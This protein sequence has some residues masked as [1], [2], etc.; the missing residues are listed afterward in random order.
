MH[1]NEHDRLE[2]N[3]VLR[4]MGF[5]SVSCLMDAWISTSALMER[6]RS[7]TGLCHNV[8]HVA[9]W[10]ITSYGGAGGANPLPH[11]RRSIGLARKT[12]FLD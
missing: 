6:L 5:T 10:P 4:R 3:Y 2:W 12:Q 9:A 7:Y 1:L 11:A 8:T